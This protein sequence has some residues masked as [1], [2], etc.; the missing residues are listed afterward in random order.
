MAEHN[1]LANFLRIF[2]RW[3]KQTHSI[4]VCAMWQPLKGYTSTL[5]YMHAAFIR[6]KRHL[7]LKASQ[8]IISMLF[9]AVELVPRSFSQWRVH[10]QTGERKKSI[11]K[12][13]FAFIHL[14]CV[15]PIPQWEMFL[16]SLAW[17]HTT[18]SQWISFAC[19]VFVSF[20]NHIIFFIPSL[21]CIR[22]AGS[23]SPGQLVNTKGAMFPMKDVFTGLF[24][25]LTDNKRH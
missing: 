24:D 21:C 5:Q 13:G 17:C 22:F 16:S 19:V 25:W 18:T 11:K 6:K 9:N 7:T 15:S 4:H 23:L 14:C 2:L 10:T 8:L 12:W 3:N 1:L 20:L